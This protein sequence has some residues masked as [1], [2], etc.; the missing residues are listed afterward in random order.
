MDS[1]CSIPDDKLTRL[2]EV[3][4]E[5]P[6]LAAVYAAG[7]QG[8][9]TCDLA[10]LFCGTLPWSRRLELELAAAGAL[11]L[12][13]VELKDLRRMPLVHRFR[14]LKRD[15]LIYVG[16]PDELAQFTEDTIA[17]YTAFYPLLEALYWKTEVNPLADDQS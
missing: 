9:G 16:Q 3:L 15:E 2:R 5:E 12:E 4:C 1:G 7:D 13:R 11:E 10:V 6:R 14:V 8:A 17:R